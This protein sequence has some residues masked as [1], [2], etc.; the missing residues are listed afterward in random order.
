MAVVHAKKWS[1]DNLMR[2]YDPILHLVSFDNQ[3]DMCKEEERE[4]AITN[5][6]HSIDC[7]MINHLHMLNPDPQHTKP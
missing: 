5:T 1:S 4:S 6:D 7:A 3:L 2:E